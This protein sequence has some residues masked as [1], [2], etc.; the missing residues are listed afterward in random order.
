VDRAALAR[1]VQGN[2]ALCEVLREMVE[3]AGR[4][5]LS[6]SRLGLLLQR[7]GFVLAEQ[8]DALAEMERIR[9]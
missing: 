6:I 1:A 8:R 2:R 4:G 5:T 3:A 9:R 7:T